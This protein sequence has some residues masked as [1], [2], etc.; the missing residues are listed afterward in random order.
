[1]PSPLSPALREVPGAT[2]PRIIRAMGVG[3]R[4]PHPLAPFRNSR[5]TKAAD[6]I[7]RART[8]PGREA[9]L[10]VLKP[11][12]A[13]CDGSTAQLRACDAQSAGAFAVLTPRWASAPTVPAPAAAP[14]PPR[15][16][17]HSHRTNA[18]AVTTRAP[19]LR[20]TGVDLVA[21]HGSSDAIAPTR[22]AEIGTARRQWP[23][24]QHGCSWLGCAPTHALAG[25]KGLRSRTRK[26]HHGAAP[27]FRMAAP[28]V[29]RS[30]GAF[31]ACSRRLQGRLGPA[32]ARVATAHTIARTV[33]NMRKERV[34][35]HAI[36][37][38]EY[39]QRCRE[40]AM[41]S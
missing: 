36:G 26:H 20:M 19:R 5:G 28:A 11:A 7:A 2:G 33:S 25:G 3:E 38:A 41:H 9:P 32:Q 12:P 13:L 18:P 10:W 35:S 37:A 1:M 34:A 27:A 16:T 23:D 17:P 24:E 14:E 8:G 22:L 21:G 6:E 15:R 30:H 4:A 31:G 40:R 39:D 29:L